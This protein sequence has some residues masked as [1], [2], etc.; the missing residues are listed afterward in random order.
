MCVQF[1]YDTHTHKISSNNSTIVFIKSVIVLLLWYFNTILHKTLFQ[2]KQNNLRTIILYY[3][4]RAHIRGAMRNEF[5]SN[6]LC[7]R[8]S[9]MKLFRKLR[10]VFFTNRNLGR[11]Y[12]RR[13]KSIQHNVNIYLSTSLYFCFSAQCVCTILSNVHAT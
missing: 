4:F 11:Q 6:L 1:V 8:K 13:K 7:L 3:L 2:V 10:S 5:I 9:F 12:L